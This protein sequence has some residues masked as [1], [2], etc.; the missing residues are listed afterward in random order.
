MIFRV[1]NCI[2]GRFSE[3]SAGT[4]LGFSRG[5]AD[6]QKKNV[7]KYC[8]PYFCRSTKLILR[9][10]PNL[11]KDTGPK[12]ASGVVYVHSD[13]VFKVVVVDL[14]ETGDDVI[15]GGQARVPGGGVVLLQLLVEF[16]VQ[17][18]GVTSDGLDVSHTAPQFGIIHERRQRGQVTIVPAG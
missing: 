18:L 4:D 7:Q 8:R 10:L 13:L 2:S 12:F 17:Q 16:M 9:A 1:I 5:V 6:F 14:E 3:C 15:G 11:H